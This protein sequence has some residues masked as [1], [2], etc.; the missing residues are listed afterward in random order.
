MFACC[1]IYTDGEYLRSVNIGVKNDTYGVMTASEMK[2]C[3][4]LNVGSL[5]CGVSASEL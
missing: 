2:F 1:A 3:Y 5:G 4:C